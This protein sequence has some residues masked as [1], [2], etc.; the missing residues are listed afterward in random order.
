MTMTS[1]LVQANTV[2]QIP[3]GPAIRDALL[4]RFRQQQAAIIGVAGVDGPTGCL[5]ARDARTSLGEAG[6]PVVPIGQ[7]R[8]PGDPVPTAAV[9]LLQDPAESDLAD[10]ARILRVSRSQGR[11]ILVIL[12]SAAGLHAAQSPQLAPFFDE[13]NLLLVPTHTEPHGTHHRI[14]P[15][16]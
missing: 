4:D 11:C 2:A 5:L 14:E 8:T 1:D 7:D 3:G 16:S 12:P 10:L 13:T 6:V 15:A 9:A